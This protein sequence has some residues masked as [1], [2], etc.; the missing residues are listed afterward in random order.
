MLSATTLA[1]SLSS[2]FLLTG[3]YDCLGTLLRETGAQP[4]PSIPEVRQLVALYGILP[5]GSQTVHENAP[6]VKSLLLA[7]PAG[8]G[9]KML[10]HAI[11][12]EAGANLFSL[13]PS[14]TVNYSGKEGL[15]MLLHMILKQGL[16]KKE[17][18]FRI[19]GTEMYEKSGNESRHMNCEEHS[20][21]PPP[22]KKKN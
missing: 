16:Q 15:I 7:G 3:Y 22:K 19:T 14:N 11:C 2:C 21:N 1:H 17:S 4:M 5:L 8:V 12:T 13:T 18:W 10:V 6:L 9:K 20:P